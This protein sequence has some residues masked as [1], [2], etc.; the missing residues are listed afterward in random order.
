MIC[1]SNIAMLNRKLEWLE[2]RFFIGGNKTLV[3]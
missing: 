1:S 3:Y 2:V